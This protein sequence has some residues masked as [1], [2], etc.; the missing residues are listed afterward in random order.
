MKNL[1]FVIALILISASCSDSKKG[2]EM[3][4]YEKVMLFKKNNPIGEKLGFGNAILDSIIIYGDENVD[5]LRIC[6]LYS[7]RDDDIGASCCS[8]LANLKSGELLDG[9]HLVAYSY[10][11]NDNGEKVRI[12]RASILLYDNGYWSAYKDCRNADHLLIMNDVL[13]S[14]K[15]FPQ[16]LDEVTT[17]DSLKYSPATS[18]YIY[19]YT[20]SGTADNAAHDYKKISTKMRKDIIQKQ[21]L[22]IENSKEI[23]DFYKMLERQ[24]VLIKYEYYSA[25]T[26]KLLFSFSMTPNQLLKR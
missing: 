26:A 3:T 9:F 21:K 8:V 22:L 23:H 19:H 1:I 12:D 13:N 18:V 16:Q 15:T 6:L 10:C 20:L 24:T 4:S 5:S 2:K 14:N 25:S 17:L 7:N 11:K